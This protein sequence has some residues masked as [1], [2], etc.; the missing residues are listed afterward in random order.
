MAETDL[1]QTRL[2]HFA[3]AVAKK[4]GLEPAYVPVYA[5]SGTLHL[6]EK[7]KASSSV[8]FA[9][10]FQSREA[11]F[12]IGAGNQPGNFFEA[13]RR[14]SLTYDKADEALD[15]LDAYLTTWRQKQKAHL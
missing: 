11:S 14:L 13:D 5:N 15:A 3:E 2:L 1:M 8:Y 6:C 12:A 10:F 9:Y 4:H 7:G